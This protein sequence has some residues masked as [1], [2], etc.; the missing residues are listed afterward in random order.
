MRKK[1][2]T[3]FHR[4]E[5]VVDGRVQQAM[6]VRVWTRRGLD[7]RA[8]VRVSRLQRLGQPL[9]RRPAIVVGEDDDRRARG[10]PGGLEPGGRRTWRSV[11]CRVSGCASS[12]AS[13]SEPVE[14]CATT[15]KRSRSSGGSESGSSSDGNRSGRSC[16]ATTT[17]ISGA[18]GAEP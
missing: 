15:S 13:V 18:I 2:H 5:N 12:S 11:P 4:P 9:A 17:A 16:D 6:L 7:D 3:A 14:S 8:G 1:T 10:A